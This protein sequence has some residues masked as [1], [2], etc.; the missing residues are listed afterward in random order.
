ML[1]VRLSILY[2]ISCEFFILDRSLII[3]QTSWNCDDVCFIFCIVAFQNNHM[4]QNSLH[5]TPK[6]VV[7]ATVHVQRADREV[8]QEVGVEQTFSRFV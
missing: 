4:L 5:A 2:R 6:K 7:S 3:A 8:L 1:S